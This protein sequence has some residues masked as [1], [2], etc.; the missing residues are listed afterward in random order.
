MP[1]PRRNAHR[2]GRYIVDSPLRD[3]SVDGALVSG[4]RLVILSDGHLD[5]HFGKTALG[6]LRYRGD[7]V[8]AMIDRDHAGRTT[9]QVVG[10]GGETPIVATL[11]EALTFEPDALLIGV[12]TRGGMIPL[13]WKPMLLEAIGAGLD[14]I[15]GLHYF[16]S[17]DPDLAAAAARSGPRLIDVRKPPAKLA[18]AEAT[19]HR[20]GC[21]VVTMVGSDC[22]VGKMSAALDIEAEARRR[23]ID[24]QFVA[25]GQTGMMIAG[26]GIPLDRVIGDFMSGAIESAVLEA[27]ENHEV[28]LVEGQGSLLHPAY[29]GV[30]LALIHGSGPT[31]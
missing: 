12:A 30:T 8:V 18:V 21:T 3:L 16:L 14:I 28:V 27:A 29:S 1:V 25:T 23:T 20:Q 6:V 17:E 11:P 7:D 9:A 22:A 10:L 26:N 31:R 24:M 19:P 2:S 13:E 4:R 15:C 5:F